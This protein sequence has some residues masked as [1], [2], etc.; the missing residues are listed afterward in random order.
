M[1]GNSAGWCQSAQEAA[2][3]KCVWIYKIWG[4]LEPS[5]EDGLEGIEDKKSKNTKLVV[6]K[7]LHT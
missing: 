5:V 2:M 7:S 6:R 4:F 1:L 3:S